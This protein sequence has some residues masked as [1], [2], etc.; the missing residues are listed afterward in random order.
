NKIN[1]NKYLRIFITGVSSRFSF[2][3]NNNIEAFDAYI[4]ETT[5]NIINSLNR[6]FDAAESSDFRLLLFDC[7]NLILNRI[8]DK[9]NIKFNLV[10]CSY[11][12]L[13]NKIMKK[14]STYVISTN[15]LCKTITRVDIYFKN[16]KPY[17]R[18]NE[19]PLLKRLSSENLK[20]LETEFNI[21]R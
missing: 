14:D 10:V 3:K 19:I 20:I 17:C 9:T 7:D 21:K 5:D 2:Y 15:P 13:I 16:G 1:Q 18:V 8:I 4:K 11:S 12:N 6:L